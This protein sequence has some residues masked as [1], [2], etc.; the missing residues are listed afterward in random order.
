MHAFG[1]ASAD[2][3]ACRLYYVNNPST[4]LDASLNMVTT[5]VQGIE[6]SYQTAT[7]QAP[8]SL[9]YRLFR[10]AIP[11]RHVPAT[12]AEGK[13]IPF[14]H[15]LQH[16]LHVSSLE[17]NRTYICIQPPSGANTTSAIPFQQQEAHASLLRH[18]FSALWSPRH[19]LS[20]QQGTSYSAGLCTV[21]V[22]ELRWTKEGPQSA[23]IQSPGVLI[24]IST[25]VGA[26]ESEDAQESK[27]TVLNDAE[28]PADTEYA[29]ALI[30]DCWSQIKSNRDLGKSEVREVMM[31]PD[32]SNSREKEMAVRM[33]CEVLRLRG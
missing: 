16:H 26:D 13:P 11:P 6:N 20:L 7:R 1:I 18:Q 3:T 14:A 4:N 8:W 30:R 9:Q 19:V 17:P 22:G 2:P 15:T 29:Q 25:I 27:N 24:C 10:D 12:D 23:G 28:E 5:L 31:A 32:S 33:W 21:Q